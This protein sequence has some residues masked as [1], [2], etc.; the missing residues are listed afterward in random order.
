M[1]W[2]K[3]NSLAH[4]EATKYMFAVTILDIKTQGT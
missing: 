3:N 4:S 1:P 2:V